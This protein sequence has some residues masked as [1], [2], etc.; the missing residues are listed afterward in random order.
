MS[1]APNQALPD[2]LPLTTIE[3][4]MLDDDRPSHPMNGIHDLTLHGP[5]DADLFQQT[6]ET[7]RRRHPLLCRIID[8][9]GKTPAW[10]AAPADATVTIDRAPAGTPRTHPRGDWLDIRTEIGLRVWLRDEP[11]THDG[12]PVTRLSLSLHHCVADALGG[13]SFLVDWFGEL[14]ARLGGPAALAPNPA[15]L[16]RRGD[17][18]DQP[19]LIPGLPKGRIALWGHLLDG[20]RRMNKTATA[21]LSPSGSGKPVDLKPAPEAPIDEATPVDD[22]SPPRTAVF[23]KQETADLRAAAKARGMTLNDLALR[24][25]YLALRNHNERV[26]PHPDEIA[27]GPTALRINVPVNLRG[28]AD[29][30]A[31]LRPAGASADLPPGGLS[32]CNK[33]GM[34]LVTRRAELAD[35][36]EALLQSVHEEMAWV[37]Q[38]ERGRRFVEA[39]RILNR[40]TTNAA[41]RVFGDTCYA[42]AVLSNLGDLRRFVPPALLD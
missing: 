34:A 12:V 35:D 17:C 16:R 23:T 38:T 2:R 9:A 29:L 18:F 11:P 22:V 8:D 40:F 26:E 32:I 21:P 24:D 25:L 1:E 28:P 10:V 33:I 3:R 15:R 27:D 4:Y 7:V 41:K 37:R 6:L 14:S 19:G 5:V 30:P 20:V 13:I 36:P 31:S 42:T 39:I